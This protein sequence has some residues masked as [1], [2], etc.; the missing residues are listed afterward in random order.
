MA[1]FGRVGVFCVCLLCARPG[2][3]QTGRD[4][5]FESDGVRMRLLRLVSRVINQLNN[6]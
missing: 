3:G 4:Q 6:C 1:S 2:A 5:F